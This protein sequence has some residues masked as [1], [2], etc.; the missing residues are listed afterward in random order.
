MAT[1]PD[2]DT[3]TVAPFEADIPLSFSISSTKYTQP[4]PVAS[5][6][7][8]TAAVSQP[9]ACQH[10]GFMTAADPLVLAE[11]IADLAGTDTDIPC[12][13]VLIR[14]DI[15][16]QLGH[17]ALHKAH[18]F[19][20]GFAL[21]IEVASPFAAADRHAREG[22]LEGLLKSE[23]LDDAGIHAGME[24]NAALIRTNHTV[25]LDAVYRGLLECPWSSPPR[26][27]EGDH[28][29]RLDDSFQNIILDILRISF[30]T[31]VIEYMNSFTAW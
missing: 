10:P 14:S 5:F 7:H 30:Q 16:V 29:L 13:H 20:V 17:E 19:A 2:P 15:F 6:R 24:A 26:H 9:F 27:A 25:E 31:G 8:E 23:K 3:T 21:R 28:A 18:H 4:Y 22:V 11:H 1:F 12:R